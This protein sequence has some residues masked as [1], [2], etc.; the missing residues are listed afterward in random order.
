MLHASRPWA[1][2]NNPNA[3][4]VFSQTPIERTKSMSRYILATLFAL[5]IYAIAAFMTAMTSIPFA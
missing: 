4:G 3:I 5:A 2:R 1:G